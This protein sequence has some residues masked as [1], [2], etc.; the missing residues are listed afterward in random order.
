MTNQDFL[1]TW[2]QNLTSDKWLDNLKAVKNWKQVATIVG[3]E[4]TR[5][6][7]LKCLDGRSRSTRVLQIR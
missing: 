3:V 1:N 6:E 5:D 2:A 4:K 7:L